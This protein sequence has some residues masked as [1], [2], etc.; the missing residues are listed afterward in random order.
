MGPTACYGVGFIFYFN[1]AIFKPI[2]GPT[3]SPVQWVLVILS[4]RGK[5]VEL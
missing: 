1:F 2:L 4:T 3:Q 5:G